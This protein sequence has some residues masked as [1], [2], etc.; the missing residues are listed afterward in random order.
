MGL[1]SRS[2]GRDGTS[3]AQRQG[4]F[5][6]AKLIVGPAWVVTLLERLRR[7]AGRRS[8]LSLRDGASLSAVPRPNRGPSWPEV[9][10]PRLSPLAF[11]V[12]APG[13]DP[14][15]SPEKF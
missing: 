15:N 6:P 11:R 12:E 3:N 7:F 13:T 14:A 1:N 2:A 9:S 8:V 5:E 4:Y 10:A